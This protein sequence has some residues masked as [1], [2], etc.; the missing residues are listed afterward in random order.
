LTTLQEGFAKEATGYSLPRLDMFLQ[1]LSQRRSADDYARSVLLL[2][3]AVNPYFARQLDELDAKAAETKVAAI[4][5]R[6]ARRME[7]T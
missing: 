5:E 4:A 2:H 6:E 1:H 7:R 3:A